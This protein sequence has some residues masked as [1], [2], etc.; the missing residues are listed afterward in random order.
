MGPESDCYSRIIMKIFKSIA[1]V[2]FGHS[3]PTA[4]SDNQ[5]CQ[6]ASA[7]DCTGLLCSWNGMSCTVQ[8]GFV[9]GSG[10]IQQRVN[11]AMEGMK[12]SDLK[13]N[14]QS[15]NDKLTSAARS[16]SLPMAFGNAIQFNSFGMGMA[17]GMASV[18]ALSG[19]GSQWGACSKSCGAGVQQRKRVCSEETNC[20][21]RNFEEK[22]CYTNCD[23]IVWSPWQLSGCSA[24]CGGG[25]ETL[26]RDCI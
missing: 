5:L 14:F 8:A 12:V 23:P 3:L 22:T 1:L 17:A 9:D 25:Y 18:G 4:N 13:S 7:D 2:S 24:T 10:T 6:A 21:G 26:S 16:A 19:A 15:N 20:P 11:E